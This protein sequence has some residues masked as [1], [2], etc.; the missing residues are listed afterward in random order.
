MVHC[1]LRHTQIFQLGPAWE[2]RKPN[3][4]LYHIRA[5]CRL[6]LRASLARSR[7]PLSS[8]MRLPP[9]FR[10]LDPSREPHAHSRVPLHPALRHLIRMTAPDALTSSRWRSA[11]RS[12]LADTGKQK[13]QCVSRRTIHCTVACS[14]IICSYI[15]C[16]QIST[17]GIS[18]IYTLLLCNC[19]FQ[20]SLRYQIIDIIKN[21]DFN[22]VTCFPVNLVK[23]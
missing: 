4:S 15:I 3:V 10:L 18:N 21:T 8:S 7:F 1:G 16:S 14:C 22:L 9:P 20:L 13:Y 6:H 17:Y 5:D 11:I 12:L 19:I 2:V 23:M